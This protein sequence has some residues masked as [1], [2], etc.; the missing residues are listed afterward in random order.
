MTSPE[1]S[2]IE[3]EAFGKDILSVKEMTEFAVATQARVA[4]QDR[5]SILQTKAKPELD[6]INSKIT[7]DSIIRAL[8]RKKEERPDSYL[9]E[10]C[11]DLITVNVANYLVGRSM[12]DL[13]DENF[14]SFSM[15]YLMAEGVRAAVSPIHSAGYDLQT[16]EMLGSN[17]LPGPASVLLENP[18]GI[19]IVEAS[20][21]EMKDLNLGQFIDFGLDLGLEF[22]QRFYE[23]GEK[24]NI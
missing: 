5:E 14:D 19:P 2:P 6:I 7:D 9:S 20:I 22:Y 4:I 13:D 21:E 18:T 8:K 23:V 16:A 10:L 3:M 12:N 1:M 17:P 24:T 15:W 11:A